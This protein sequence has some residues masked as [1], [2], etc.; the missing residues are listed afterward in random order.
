AQAYTMRAFV[1]FVLARTYGG[2]PLRLEPTEGFDPVAIQVARSTE[3]Q[4]FASIKSDIDAAIGLYST[5]NTVTGKGKWS[6]PAANALKG[7]VYLWTGRRL[8]GGTPDAT[9]ALAALNDA[10]AAPGVGLEANYADVF[11]YTNKG[12]KE[13]LMAVKFS[14]TEGGNQVWAQNMYSSQASYPAYV[15]ASQIAIVGTPLAGNGNVWRITPNVRGQFSNSD[16]RKAA[17][18]IDLQG[19]NPG[20]YYTTYGLKYN[21]TVENGTRFFTSDFVLYRLGD[22]LLLRAEAKN[23]LLQDPSGD[24]NT[25][26]Q[27]A[28]G[29]G[30]P[31]FVNG[32]QTQNYDAILQERLFELTLEAKRWWDLIRFGKAFDLVPSLVGKSAQTHLLYFPIGTSTTAKETKVTETPG[33]Q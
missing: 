4:V 28:Y 20:E 14:T 7:D 11:R 26:R 6:K 21:G 2:V 8:G 13:I 17:T 19:T 32:S 16:T 24:M 31:V 29:A 27:R 15:P 22:V 5:N 33:W 1:Y 25:I 23:A 10:V 12:N 18:Y 9:I 30:Y 3:A